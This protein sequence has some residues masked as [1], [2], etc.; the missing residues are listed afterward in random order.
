MLHDDLLALQAAVTKTASFNGAGLACG[1]TAKS[2]RALFAQ[3]LF[4][5]ASNA[6]GSNTVTFTIEHSDDNST[7][8]LLASGADQVITLTTTAQHGQIF[9]PIVTDKKYVRLVVT[10]A[11]SGTVPTITYH[12]WVGDAK[13]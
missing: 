5:A 9:I 11:G 12:A 1:P 3:I 6:T 2:A 4:S 13:A 8:Y 10:V 7:F